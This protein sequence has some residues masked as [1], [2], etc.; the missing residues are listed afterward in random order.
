MNLNA[1]INEILISGLDDW[2]DAAEVAF[3]AK[4]IGGAEG[5]TE[6]RALSVR[7]IRDLIMEGL[8]DVGDVTTEGFRPWNLS[9][10][11][12]LKRIEHEWTSLGRWP[13]I[14]EICWLSNT[15]KGDMQAND[16]R[17]LKSE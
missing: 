11:E 15:E 13:Q 12:A 5:D 7:V 2:V 4:S 8:V 10:D 6:N 3:V 17:K 1:C 9:V 14:G 16:I